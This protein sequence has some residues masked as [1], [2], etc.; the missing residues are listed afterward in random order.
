MAN[1][2]IETAVLPNGEM[3]TA[4]HDVIE[5]VVELQ[6]LPRPLTGESKKRAYELVLKL[7]EA[8]KK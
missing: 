8:E 6:K 5:I 1:N 3:M 7:H 4:P 2:W